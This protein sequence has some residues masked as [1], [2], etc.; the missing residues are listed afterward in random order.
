MILRIVLIFSLFSTMGFTARLPSSPLLL[1]RKF[2]EYIVQSGETLATIA[3]DHHT[4][5]HAIRSI[6]RL[7]RN[8]RVEAGQILSLPRTTTHRATPSSLSQKRKPLKQDMVYVIKEGDTLFTI[9]RKH[10]TTVKS[11]LDANGMKQMAPIRV[12]QKLTLPI[13]TTVSD[14]TKNRDTKPSKTHARRTYTVAE[15][16]TLFSVARKNHIVIRDLM[17]MNGLGLTDSLKVGQVLTVSNHTTFIPEST[18]KPPKKSTGTRRKLPKRALKSYT[19]K[20]GDTLWLIAKKFHTTLSEIRKLN[21]MKK[22]ASIHVGSILAV[23]KAPHPQPKTYTVHKGDTLWLIAKKHNLSIQ[24]LRTLNHMGRKDRI[25]T[26]KTLALSKNVTKPIVS[27]A[28]KPHTASRPYVRKK[29]HSS[30]LAVFGTRTNSKTIRVAK[31]YLGRRYV[32]GAEGPNSFDC[33]GFTQYVMRK[34]RGVSIPRLSR[35]QAYYGRY[36]T[37]SHLRPG[38]LIFFDTSHRRRGYVNHVG[39]YIGN[40]KF[41]HASS[42]RHRV[43]ITSLDRP[44]YSARFKWGRRI[45]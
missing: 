5:V 6:N 12:G 39:I 34:S 1:M 21:K 45:H 19:V 36:I 40:H 29:R 20:K 42:A 24:Q 9:A 31:R 38:D 43:V 44:F 16:D 25:H 17:K 23:G 41:I 3:R 10:H 8:E 37:R 2:S 14:L 15:G 33:S 35:K 28:A 32:W 11:L 30:P 22:G 4:T 7:T 13:D 26:G 27:L 18:V